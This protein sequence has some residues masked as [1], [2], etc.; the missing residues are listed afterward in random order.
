MKKTRPRLMA[1][2][3]ATFILVPGGKSIYEEE[4][5]TCQVLVVG[6]H[7]SKVQIMSPVRQGEQMWISNSALSKFNP[8]QPLPPL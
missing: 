3:L 6:G 7:N 5:F 8:P 4:R 1:G 2:D